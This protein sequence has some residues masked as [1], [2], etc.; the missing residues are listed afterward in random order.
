MKTINLKDFFDKVNY[1][2]QKDQEDIKTI[3]HY[4]KTR[5]NPNMKEFRLTY[6]T[7]QTF[8]IKAICEWRNAETFFEI[9]TGRGTACYAVSLLDSVRDIHTVDIL[10]FHQ[11]FSTAIGFKKA[12]VSLSDI[13]NMIPFEAKNKVKFYHRKKFPVIHK[14]YPKYFD[15]CFIDG[16]HSD[17]RVIKEDYELCNHIVKDGGVIIWD[18]YEPRFAVKQVVD[19]VLQKD[20]NLEALLVPQR[21]HLFPDKEPELDRGIVIMGYDL[22]QKD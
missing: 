12:V 1:N 2:W 16:D 21:G 22:W 9:G 8:L 19:E 10:N 15:V 4:T 18:D 13:R 14:D 3:C 6:G 20:K 5:V 11:K 7:E 17:V